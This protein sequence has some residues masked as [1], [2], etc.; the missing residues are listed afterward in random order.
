VVIPI[1]ILSAENA[2]SA[3]VDEWQ[4]QWKS[5][6]RQTGNL[7]FHFVIKQYTGTKLTR[8]SATAIDCMFPF[9]RSSLL[10]GNDVKSC[11]QDYYFHVNRNSQDDEWLLDNIALVSSLPKLTDWDFIPAPV[12][13]SQADISGANSISNVTTNGLRIFPV[14]LPSLAREKDF[15]VISV[16]NKN[17]N[18]TALVVLTFTF[19]TTDNKLK[20]FCPIEGEVTLL[21]DHYYLICEGRYTC[22]D[23]VNQ[24]KIATVVFHNEYDFGMMTIPVLKK[25]STEYSVASETTRK[26]VEYSNYK[27]N[28]GTDPARFMLSHYGFPEPDF[29]INQPVNPLRFILITLGTALIV[30]A[31]AMMYR[32]RKK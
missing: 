2:D 9:Y 22:Y 8:E 17:E 26:I 19:H 15:Q 20:V 11:N 3:V 21:P 1:N 28:E 18:G 24:S 4:Q 25:Q 7:S 6:L 12:N 31:L 30:L 27:R 5:Y 13:A 14:W 23:D 16:E 10:S 29:K 32:K